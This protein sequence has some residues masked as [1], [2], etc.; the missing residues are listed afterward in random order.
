M[1][2][3]YVP[4]VPFTLIETLCVLRYMRKV[5][6]SLRKDLMELQER[7]R[8]GNNGAHDSAVLALDAETAIVEESIRKLWEAYNAT[9]PPP[10]SSVP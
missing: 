1:P 2:L 3:I 8:A 9:V 5:R 6:D 4:P 10:A 7:I